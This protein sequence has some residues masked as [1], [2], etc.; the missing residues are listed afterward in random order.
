VAG[1]GRAH[2]GL[3]KKQPLKAVT[4]SDQK[5]L[6]GMLEHLPEL[7]KGVAQ[8]DAGIIT[9]AFERAEIRQLLR[10]QLS[11]AGDPPPG[12]C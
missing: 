1:D 4:E 10:T 2:P 3:S 8:A 5:W 12:D 11:P 9:E 6:A 7:T